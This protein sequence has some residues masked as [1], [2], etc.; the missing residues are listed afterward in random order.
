MKTR[1][2]SLIV[3]AAACLPGL[4]SAQTTP[5]Q[6]IVI[7]APK[8]MSVP[9]VLAEVGQR[10]AYQ[11]SDGHTLVVEGRGRQLRVRHAGQSA[12]LLRP[13]EQGRFVSA[14]QQVALQMT[15]DAS[16][17]ALVSFSYPGPAL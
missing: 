7:T 4:A 16:G 13:N 9:A 6:Q 11:M 17:E 12:H 14:D 15:R 3:A 10:V 2:L 8:L 5:A 1:S